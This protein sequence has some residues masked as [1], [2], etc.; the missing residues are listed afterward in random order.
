MADDLALPFAIPEE[1]IAFIF[2]LLANDDGGV[3]VFGELRL[4]SRHLKVG[5][6][7]AKISVV[8]MA[9]L[10]NCA[11]VW[12][13]RL[14]FVIGVGGEADKIKQHRLRPM[15]LRGDCCRD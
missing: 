3:G 15:L 1:S 5:V 10:S 14:S 8:G 9:C 12:S 2:V 7:N 6:S 13:G 11:A 4:A